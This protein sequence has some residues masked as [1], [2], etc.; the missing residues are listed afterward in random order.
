MRFAKAF[1]F[2]VVVAQLDVAEL[3]FLHRVILRN[4][5]VYIGEKCSGAHTRVR[6][7]KLNRESCTTKYR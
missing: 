1:V 4:M 5:H 6:Y 7:A 2:F 3:K